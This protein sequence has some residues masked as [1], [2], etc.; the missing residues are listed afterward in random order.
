MTYALSALLPS[1]DDPR[2]FPYVARL[3]PYPAGYD[4]RVHAGEIE[5]QGG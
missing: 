1:P 5:D 2:D 4:Q 3:G